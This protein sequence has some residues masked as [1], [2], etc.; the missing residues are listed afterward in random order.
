MLFAAAA[1]AFVSCSQDRAGTPE[2]PENKHSIRFAAIADENDVD[3]PESRTSFDSESYTIRWQAG[4]CVGI[5]IDA[6]TP[7]TNAAATPDLTTTPVTFEATTGVQ[8]Y[9]E[10]DFIYAYYPYTAPEQTDAK[11]VS[12]TIPPKQVQ[13]AV[14]R[15][16]FD[17]SC[18]P[19]VA[20]PRQ[21]TGAAENEASEELLFRQTA[22]MIEFDI[23]TSNSAYE[24][25]RIK[26]IA[27]TN[28]GEEY[29]AGTFRY[30]LTAVPENG[31]LPPID[32][33]TLLG[34]KNRRI[35]V[36]LTTQSV[37]GGKNG[38]TGTN[39]IY[40]A[41][42][43]GTYEGT[44]TVTT[45]KAVY[46]FPPK[47]VLELPRAFVRRILLDLGTVQPENREETTK[48]IVRPGDDL[49]A[50]IS[51]SERQ[52][53]T[54]YLM[55][56][57]YT[58]A[59]EAPVVTRNLVLTSDDPSRTVVNAGVAFRGSGT[60]DRLV[61][62]NIRF[63][64][65]TYLC[66]ITNTDYDIGLY[67]IEN[68]IVDLNSGATAN[69]TLFSTSGTTA[70]ASLQ[71]LGTYEVENSVVFANA[72]QA[73]NIVYMMSSASGIPQFG[74]LLL[75]NSTFANCARGLVANSGPEDY[76]FE[77][78]IE[79][80]TLYNIACSGNYAIVDIRNKGTENQSNRSVTLRN[81]VIWFG[82]SASKILQFAGS[83]EGQFVPKDRIDCANFYHFASQTPAFGSSA[84]NIADRMT[85]YNGTP[86]ELWQNP[87]A[88]P[89]AAG[90]SFRIKDQSVRT[91]QE[92]A[93]TTLGDPRWE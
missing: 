64:C 88:D 9:E 22:A 20:V 2:T 41:A 18:N 40:M 63:N 61:F 4:D 7:T 86:D 15:T 91:A 57:E 1:T 84:Y 26:S 79:N 50:I 30:D 23:V 45:D 24:G 46:T 8:T 51:D 39:L 32:P 93:G 83:G 37:V 43:P 13:A 31:A 28:N 78:A 38:T 10:G 70:N 71:R 52:C 11:A 65:A 73:Q 48:I 55:A 92:A 19:L 56:G 60:F 14:G 58:L 27:Y 68:C 33:A 72:G 17:G 89:S 74:K 34:D 59:D 5:Y 53:D 54:V 80:C 85:P 35:E 29:I 87:M 69:S 47:K 3:G 81:S 75:K 21:I 67:R 76:A 49:A 90:A 77:V 12:L 42:I 82:G 25:E 44:L 6:A 62:R 36:A 16:N 66:Q